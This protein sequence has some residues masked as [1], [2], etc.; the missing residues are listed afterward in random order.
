MK[1]L[2]VNGLLALSLT[3]GIVAS[4]IGDSTVQAQT[5]SGVPQ[6]QRQAEVQLAASDLVIWDDYLESG[7]RIRRTDAKITVTAPTYYRLQVFQRPLDGTTISNVRYELVNEND[8]RGDRS[9][10]LSGNGTHREKYINLLPGT[11]HIEYISRHNSPIE[12]DVHLYPE[13]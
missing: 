12:L 1:K 6:I 11:Y 10:E 13:P 7:R 3:A 2:V 5:T 8:V 4:P 9:F